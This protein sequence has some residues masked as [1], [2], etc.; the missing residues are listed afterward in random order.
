MDKAER[1][2]RERTEARARIQAEEDRQKLLL[3]ITPVD[4]EMTAAV[5]ANVEDLKALVK[6]F[7]NAFAIFGEAFQKFGHALELRRLQYKEEYEDEYD[8][9]FETLE[10]MTDDDLEAEWYV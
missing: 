1:R 7:A 2:F 10:T 9:M 5:E 6:E 4:E 8:E 3:K